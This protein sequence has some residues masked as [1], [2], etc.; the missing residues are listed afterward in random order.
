MLSLRLGRPYVV[1]LHG[2]EVWRPLRARDRWGLGGAKGLW[3]NSTHTHRYFLRHN[4]SFARLPVRR[5]PW[6]APALAPDDVRTNAAKPTVFR[7]LCVSRLSTGDTFGRYRGVGDLYKGFAVLFDALHGL[8]RA[9]PRVTLEIVGEGDA[10][11]DLEAYAA[12][13]GVADA[14]IFHGGLSDESL[15]RRY[16]DADV[17]V[18]P[19]EREGF[20]LVFTEAMARGLPCVG[21]AAGAVPEVIEN[22]VSGLLVPPG[23]GD[24]LADA[25]RTLVENPRL[26]MRL[27]AAARH[28][29]EEEFTEAACLRRLHE[30]LGDL[31]SPAI[32]GSRHSTHVQGKGTGQP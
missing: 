25:L 9:C 12:R 19:S 28:R 3:T 10:R 26:R 1:I 16:A 30:A 17:F 7:L 13:R 20:G 21:V 15:A 8:R 11:E 4:P 14:L 24:A 5:T 31:G 2:V 27:G 22:G 18:M 32:D 23:D 29:F 6:P